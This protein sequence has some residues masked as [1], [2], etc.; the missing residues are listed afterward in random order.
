MHV[1]PSQIYYASARQIMVMSFSLYGTERSNEL[2]VNIVV[3]EF[4]VGYY[5]V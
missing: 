2:A 4:R 3:R 1:G 5:N